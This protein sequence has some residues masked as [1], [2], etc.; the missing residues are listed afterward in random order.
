M[1]NPQNQLAL[2]AGAKKLSGTTESW[3]AQILSKNTVRKQKLCGE[4][5]T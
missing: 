1:R 2:G 5:Y 3:P 4:G